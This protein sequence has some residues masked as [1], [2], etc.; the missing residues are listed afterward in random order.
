MSNHAPSSIHNLTA[1]ISGNVVTLSWSD[2]NTLSAGV[3]IDRTIAGQPTNYLPLATVPA[4]TTSYQDTATFGATYN[5]RVTALPVDS[6]M[7]VPAQPVAVSA[8]IAGVPPHVYLQT[9][10]V[11]PV[12]VM[13]FIGHSVITDGTWGGP[14]N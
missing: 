10:T 11:D 1:S 7:F 2:P 8:V 12:G 13:G 4:G 14:L 5:Y 9:P 6:T 3:Q